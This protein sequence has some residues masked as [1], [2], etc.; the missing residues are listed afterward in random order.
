MCDTCVAYDTK[1]I[2]QEEYYLHKEMKKQ[3]REEKNRDKDSASVA[4]VFTMDL[5][6]VPQINCKLHVLQNEISGT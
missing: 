6:V 4:A 5:Q 1:N 2:E 3:A